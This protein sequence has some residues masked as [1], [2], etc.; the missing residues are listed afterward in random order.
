MNAESSNG[1]H[2]TIAS[3][4][5]PSPSNRLANKGLLSKLP[6]H[7]LN[8]KKSNRGSRWCSPGKE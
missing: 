7:K 2:D 6:K 5:R 8:K 3:I 1:N 4:A